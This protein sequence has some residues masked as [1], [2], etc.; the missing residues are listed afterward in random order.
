M[1]KVA[2]Y[3]T[4]RQGEGN[5]G[6]LRGQKFLGTDR[7]VGTLYDIGPFPCAVLDGKGQI[8]VEVYDEIDDETL[9]NLDCLEGYSG[10]ESSANLY[11][12]RTVRT[13]KGEFV[14]TYEW[15]GVVRENFLK[16]EDGDW[17]K[18]GHG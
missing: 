11:N 14:E 2:V 12:R 17:I 4:L 5:H 3:G 10:Q 9:S 1:K 7:I 18:H 8:V 15:A 16:I 6:L 13:E